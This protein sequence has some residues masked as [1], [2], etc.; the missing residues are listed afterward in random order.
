M[1][2]S[3]AEASRLSECKSHHQYDHHTLQNFVTWRDGPRWWVHQKK[4]L[5]HWRLWKMWCRD[6][7]RVKTNSWG[8]WCNR[9]TKEDW[10]CCIERRY[11]SSS[12]VD[13]E[14]GRMEDSI[15]AAEPQSLLERICFGKWHTIDW[16]YFFFSLPP[17]KELQRIESYRPCDRTIADEE[18]MMVR[19]T[20]HASWQ[21]SFR[22]LLS[23]SLWTLIVPAFV[24]S[25][26]QG[27]NATHLC[28]NWILLSFGHA[29]AK[30]SL[31]KFIWQKE[32]NQWEL[33]LARNW[34]LQC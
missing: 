25:A 22:N 20:F 27:A 18:M 31:G 32:E 19:A 2:L 11:G 15:V 21:V 6:E 5:S 4:M 29:K 13:F 16:I 28:S 14:L 17:D 24:F 34:N 1:A 12:Y 8:M 26:T 10:V 33:F 9:K 3:D 30:E 7:R 23:F